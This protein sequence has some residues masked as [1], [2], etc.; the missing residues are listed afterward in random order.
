[1][2]KESDFVI[3]QSQKMDDACCGFKV[4]MAAL[5]EL[6]R[7]AQDTHECYEKSRLISGP[8]QIA[9][10]DNTLLGTLVHRMGKGPSGRFGWFWK[11]ERAT[12]DMHDVFV[13]RRRELLMSLNQV[14]SKLRCRAGNARTAK[15]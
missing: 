3:V 11:I 13:R 6:K 7:L 4:H 12:Q 8:P 1:M 9:F 5:M 2:F 15:T 10:E 14:H